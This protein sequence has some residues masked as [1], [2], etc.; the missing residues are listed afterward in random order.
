MLHCADTYFTFAA[1]WPKK[2]HESHCTAVEEILVICA[3]IDAFSFSAGLEFLCTH[4]HFS[5]HALLK[6]N[7]VNFNRVAFIIADKR[8]AGKHRSLCDLLEWKMFPRLEN[9]TWGQTSLSDAVFK[10]WYYLRCKKLLGIKCHFCHVRS[11]M[12]VTTGMQVE[13][14]NSEMDS[15]L[16]SQ[17]NQSFITYIHFFIFVAC[18]A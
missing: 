13:N 15:L 2:H 4:F 11:V 3:P 5:C 12:D 8:S 9:H 14:I 1:V 18:V 17:M 6:M 7:A 16:F 10:S